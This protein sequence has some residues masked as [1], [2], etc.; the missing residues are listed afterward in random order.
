MKF[1]N[2]IMDELSKL[3]DLNNYRGIIAV[4]G[5]WGVILGTI[6]ISI[7]MDN[8]FIYLFAVIIIGT[9]QR[10]LA[11][12]LHESAHRVLAKNTNLNDILGKYFSGY[13]IFQTFQKYAKSHVIL[14]HN[15][16]GKK[17]RDPDYKYY[18][19]SDLF[20]E[21]TTRHFIIKHLISP[22]F[23]SK[24][25]SFLKYLLKNRLGDFNDPEFKK[26]F[27][28]WITIAAISIYT[29]SFH[30]LVL[31]WF[32]PLI[33]SFPMVGWFIEMAEHFPIIENN[34]DIDQTW[35]RFSSKPELL[36]TGMHAEN[37]HL[38]HHLMP[39]IPFWNLHKAHN[40]MMRD[41]IYKSRNDDMGGIFHSVKGRK[42]LW[43]KILTNYFTNP[44][45]IEVNNEKG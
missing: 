29:N 38:T 16:L 42:S 14:H 6:A 30:L 36:L 37:L 19:E 17:N 21:T 41:P 5:D 32:I 33:T 18:I 9:R 45:S 43:S 12:I 28:L 4:A 44:R 3:S 24:S 8:I 2:E 15:Y 22:L 1:S 34:N 39:N 7:Y 10:A 26:L 35:N 27:I 11:T 20:Q 31:Y 13:T 23:L 40:I 25:P